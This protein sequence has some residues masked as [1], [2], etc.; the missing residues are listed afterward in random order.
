MT[1]EAALGELQREVQTLKAEGE[2][3][4]PGIGI[5]SSWNVEAVDIREQP[6]DPAHPWAGTV[7]FKIENRI[8]D[9]DGSTKV[10]RVSRSY[11]F[12]YDLAAKRWMMQYKP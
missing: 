12:V 2:K 1:R 3:P 9:L 6:N 11:D 7:R 5:Q 10:Q 8:R 4:D